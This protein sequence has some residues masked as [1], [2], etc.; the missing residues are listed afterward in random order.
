MLNMTIAKK[1]RFIK[2]LSSS[3]KTVTI[4]LLIT[5][6]LTY[7]SYRFLS[8]LKLGGWQLT[9]NKEVSVQNT[10]PKEFHALT[11]NDSSIY[12]GTNDGYTYSLNSVNGNLGWRHEAN[13]YS[14]YPAAFNNNSIMFLT[15]FDGY[16]YALDKKSGKQKWRFSTDRIKVDTEPVVS[17]GLVL[18]GNRNGNLYALEQNTGS[19]KWVFKTKPIDNKILTPDPGIIHFGRFIADDKNVYLNSS[20]EDAI[21]TIDKQT[22]EEKWRFA[23]YGFSFQKPQ[24]YPKSISFWNYANTYYILDKSTGKLLYF[25]ETTPGQVFQGQKHNY[26]IDD[27]NNINLID[28]SSG[29]NLWKYSET[30][31]QPIK[32][33]EVGDSSIIVTDKTKDS[34]RIT[35]LNVKTGKKVWSQNIKESQINIVLA[36]LDQIYVIGKSIQCAYDFK[37][38]KKW[39]A[40]EKQMGDISFLSKKGLFLVS[41]YEENTDIILLNKKTGSFKWK[42]SSQIVN[43]SVMKEHEGDLYFISKDKK[44]IFMLKG[45]FPKSVLTNSDLVIKNKQKSKYQLATD[46]IQSSLNRRLS[47]LKNKITINVPGKPIPANSIYELTLN[48][49]DSYYLNA[50]DDSNISASFTNEAG[51][52]YETKAFYYDQNTW[53]IRFVPNKEGKWKWEIK[54][55]DDLSF[56]P[57]KADFTVVQGDNPGFI[58]ISKT[59]QRLFTLPNGNIFTPIGIQDCIYDFNQN[60]DPLDQW[61]LGTELKPLTNATSFPTSTLETHLSTY[62]KSGFNMYRWGSGNCSFKLWKGLSSSGNRY[63]LNEGVWVDKLFSELK[64]QGFHIWISLFS[65]S[66]PSDINVENKQTQTMLKNYLEYTISRY[67]SYV[68]VWELA[69]EIEM[70]DELINFMSDYIRKNDPYHHPITTSWERADLPVIDISSIHWYSQECDICHEE[71]LKKQITDNKNVKKPVV[72]SEQGNWHTNWD[73]LSAIRM[74][75]RLWVGFFEKMSFIFWNY[76]RELFMNRQGEIQGPSNIYLGPVER[77][78]I[79]VFD[80]FTKNLSSVPQK[81]PIVSQTPEDN[82]YA[83][84]Y[85]QKQIIGYI[86][87]Q[88]INSPNRYASFLINIPTDGI[89][90]WISSESGKVLLDQ[91]IQKG[92]Q[93]IQ[94]PEFSTDIVFRI[95]LADVDSKKAGPS[96]DVININTS[97]NQVLQN[98]IYEITLVANAIDDINMYK[99][100]DIY[101]S[102]TD[103][104]GTA[105]QTK[106][107][108][109]DKSTWKIRFAPNKE[110]VWT[111]KIKTKDNLKPSIS[112]GSFNVTSSDSLGFIDSHINSFLYTLQNGN[113]FAP[114]GLKE[115]TNGYIN[116]NDPI[117]NW[118]FGST[119]SSSKTAHNTQLESL[120]SSYAKN[121]FNMFRWGTGY[122]NPRIWS[123]YPSF[124][125][126]NALNEGVRIDVL[127]SY[128]R[129]NRIHIWWSFTD[130]LL[131]FNQLPETKENQKLLKSYLDYIVSRYSSYVDVWELVNQTSSGAEQILF[132]S[133]YI[134]SIDPYKRLII[135]S[136]QNSVFHTVDKNE[137]AKTPFP[138]ASKDK[139]YAYLID[140]QI[141]GYV[142]KTKNIDPLKPTYIATNIPSNSIFQWI[143]PETDTILEEQFVEKGPQI[144]WSP[145]FSDNIL[146]K[147]LLK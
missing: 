141:V 76:S 87:R 107:F 72:F 4:F 113:I 102:F 112:E 83:N 8:N 21:I 115:C 42:Y 140:K 46:T 26:I 2:L 93:I 74:R 33:K 98:N 80:S 139:T 120:L 123:I 106:A 67:S 41:D 94:S 136:P 48:M 10:T 11:V 9:F 132:M 73:Y 137:T 27:D 91:K 47:F 126:S 86:Y 62:A 1:R 147:I 59:D 78:S 34:V 142:F 18:F 119:A 53:K 44:S 118:L 57:Q 146:F 128:L 25:I 122:C 90:K 23:N 117:N 124:F 15:N 43:T 70:D 55:K 45:S 103:E 81:Y 17:D 116:H 6:V 138:V 145:Q 99:N 30:G 85:G 66:L 111:W 61:F 7:A 64:N 35:M 127:F 68:D 130:F 51:D 95:E 5:I 110:G 19:L 108:Y 79:S 96:D 92:A 133:K 135:T 32:V 63:G 39:C 36:D 89:I 14:I 60:G 50:Y 88:I 28:T 31:N 29:L 58:S 40:H 82:I 109:Y 105:Y 56:M 143:N 104:K 52:V 49:N 3:S 144:L 24:V 12:I 16:L 125:I 131:V 77:L 134:N 97:T 71:D 20:T 84:I 13:D 121:G 101:A 75:I 22:G 100:E 129:K 38:S 37:G 114:I 69:N 54:N 65:F